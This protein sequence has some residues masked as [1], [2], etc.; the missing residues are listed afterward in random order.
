MYRYILVATLVSTP[1]AQSIA[2]TAPATGPT[3]SVATEV[4][5]NV[6]GG[7][8]AHE[9]IAVDATGDSEDGTR[10][11]PSNAYALNDEPMA[12]LDREPSPAAPAL[13]K[14]DAGVAAPVKRR[15]QKSAPLPTNEPAVAW[16]AS[17]EAALKIRFVGPASFGNAIAL[18]AENAFSNLETANR[19][20][21]VRD[22]QGQA[23]SA[24][25]VQSTN[26]RMLLLSVAP[27][28]YTVSIGAGLTDAAGKVIGKAS[29]GPVYVR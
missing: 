1:S 28:P 21:K 26:P 5:S 6:E 25:W 7:S 8:C 13:A 10:I 22:S 12:E 23:V 14:R 18:L 20:I 3:E 24:K 4:S 15:I 17:P 11:E 19:E 9:A 27:G 2:L 16:W 29:E